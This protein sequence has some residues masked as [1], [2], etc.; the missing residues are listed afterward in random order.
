ML[1][2]PSL[3]VRLCYSFPVLMTLGLYSGLYYSFVTGYLMVEEGLSWGG[4][5]GFHWIMGMGL[6][7]YV[8]AILT[9]PGSVP[10]TF[11]LTRAPEDPRPAET[12]NE[13]DYQATRPSLCDKCNRHRPPRAHHCSGCQRCILRMD[14]H[15][16]W[17]G[18]CVGLR[19]HKFFLLFLFY[20]SLT[21]LASGCCCGSVLIREDGIGSWQLVTNT[22]GGLVLFSAL[23]GLCMFHFY[24][25]I[26]NRSSLEM[27]SSGYN[28]FDTGHWHKNFTQLFGTDYTTWLVPVQ[29]KGT[30][31]GSDYPSNPRPRTTEEDSSAL[32]NRP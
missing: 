14:H 10:A 1:F 20:T 23:A 26:S 27:R 32:I 28:V 24:M 16:P 31:D 11:E 2:H 4:L 12:L 18:N 15:C 9:D 22:L 7:A 8:Q 30:S 3:P 25:L 19:N 29:G 13:S 5:V 21:L 17:V 6:W